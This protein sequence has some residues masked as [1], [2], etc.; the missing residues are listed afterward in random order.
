MRK[1]ISPLT[2][3]PE[4]YTRSAVETTLLIGLSKV[5]KNSQQQEFFHGSLCEHQ[6][7]S[8]KSKGKLWLKK[9]KLIYGCWLHY[10]AFRLRHAARASF[11][12]HLIIRL[13]KNRVVRYL[14]DKKNQPRL[15]QSDHELL[16][17]LL[18]I[19]TSISQKCDAL[20][21]QVNEVVACL[22]NPTRNTTDTQLER[23]RNAI[24]MQNNERFK[25]V[26][27]SISVLRNQNDGL[28]NMLM[29]LEGNMTSRND[30]A[31]SI[32]TSAHHKLD[33]LSIAT[34]QVVSTQRQCYTTVSGSD[35]ICIQYNWDILLAVP[36]SDWRLAMYLSM[37]G[38]FEYGT[39][40]LF[41]EIIQEGMI[42]LDIGANCGIYSLHALKQNA[43][44]YAF[45][46]TPST[47]EILRQNVGM[48]GYEFST[49]VHLFNV[50]AANE[51]STAS[52]HISDHT[53][54]HNSMFFQ[55]ETSHQIEVKTERIDRLLK[56]VKVD[57]FKLDVE[58]AEIIALDG[59][60]ELLHSNDDIIGFIE[61]SPNN[62]RHAATDPK[63]LYEMLLSYGFTSIQVINEADGSLI[64][65]TSYDDIQSV[66]SVNLL[67][68][69]EGLS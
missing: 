58:G 39:E 2:N 68:K 33:Q 13:K 67:L 11:R 42:V 23:T 43:E 28:L 16:I 36:N 9:N 65:V 63:V 59:M 25:Q 64:P 40:K 15:A 14:I 1:E 44:V 3:T 35:A 53:C 12:T 54:G 37:G 69:K 55:G 66:D 24:T 41:R 19:S 22:S 57:C 30:T 5:D 48:N 27:E 49:K 38:Y 6:D 8:W 20:G 60:K 62:L 47:F 17:Q 34:Q 46:P 61:F 7:N 26:W 4:Q 51:S 50:A 21:L 56:N 32:L 31:L 52:L 18:T 45:E 29:H 10:K